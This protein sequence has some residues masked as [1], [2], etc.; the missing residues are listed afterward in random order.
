MKWFNNLRIGN[1]LIICFL[2][3]ALIAGVVGVIGIRDINKADEEYSALY[4]RY[5]VSLSYLTEITEAFQRTRVN[6]RDIIIE[7]GTSD[8]RQQYVDK[9][10]E[11]DKQLAD[12]M[13][14][15]EKT[16]V[17]DQ[18][19]QQSKELKAAI[20]SYNPVRDRMV[21]LAMANQEAPAHELMRGDGYTL[22]MEVDNILGEMV[23]QNIR[24]GDQLAKELSGNSRN[25]I[26]TM[27]A[28]VVV[29]MLLA[30]VLGI[31]IARIISKPINQL[32]QVA[33]KL[34]LG[35]V[36]VNIDAAGKDEIGLLMNS[37]RAM[38]ANIK[39]QAEDANK[40]ATGNLNIDVN[41]KS[42]N[43]ILGKSMKQVVETL[44]C[45]ITEMDNMSKLHDAGDIDITITE[46]DFEGAYRTMAKGVNEMVKGHINLNKKAMA[47][48]AEFGKGNFD[49]PLE[50]FP[51]K[52]A[53]INDNIEAMRKNLKDV[54]TEIKKLI[55]AS[56]EG[57]L[58]ERADAGVFQGDWAVL[59]RGLNGLIDALIE[60]IK[61]A[62]A[63]LDEM[64]NGNLHVSV[65]GDY[66]GDHAAIK[67]ALNDT[68]ETLLSYVTEISNTLTE[69]ANGNLVIGITSDYRGDF[70]DIKDSLNLIIRSFNEVLGEINGAAEQV[71]SGA[72]QVSDSSLTLSQGSTEQASS[73]E[74][75]TASIEEIATQTKQN[76]LNANQA[77]E[78]AMQVKDNAT[79]G[80]EQMQQ[81]L[82]S[83]AEI[84][85]SSSNISK[86]IKVIDEIAFQTNILALNAAV[87]AA[88]AGQ[89]GKGFAVVAEE[90]RNLAARSANAAKETTMLIEGSINKVADGTRIANDTAG[91]LNSMVEGV[92]KAATLVA[93]I[94]N[95]SNEQASG[96]AQINQGIIQISQVTQT[97]SATA[98]ESASASEEL[99]SQADIMKGMIGKFRLKK[100]SHSVSNVE[101]LNPE[102]LKMLENMSAKEQAA[103]TGEKKEKKKERESK[104]SKVKISLGDNEF[105][106]Y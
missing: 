26:I 64:A 36:D 6:T 4:N 39:L 25:T 33:D 106:K 78:L 22:A 103:A 85:E 99:S 30:I 1:K 71:A 59:V 79:K 8:D 67:N 62:A 72:R 50:K 46:E 5:G 16:A 58:N 105:G 55:E 82:K 43:D 76:A 32:A 38:I 47:C 56:S 23:E 41:V 18:E 91:A 81:M 29:C 54:N 96:I 90:V 65:T 73:I 66:K 102:I 15:Y 28:V 53:F 37:F 57:R 14:L 45:L 88:R 17:T 84:N 80:N 68:I 9:I 77:S 51:G 3:V 10:K 19:K 89:H 7:I 44:R 87:E 83:M 13:L 31:V 70:I 60:P 61:E 24:S 2:L 63:V 94:A 97:N 86:I 101:G 34:A 52:K 100:T 104:L 27:I 11:F 40:I 35:D 48:L 49:A 12:N 74:E 21:S 69:M 93:D 92:A 20:D 75:L 95:A 98:E 42:E